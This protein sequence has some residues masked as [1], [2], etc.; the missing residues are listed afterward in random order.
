M[1][2]A[3]A[4]V[5]SLSAPA[6]AAQMKQRLYDISSGPGT[7][8]KS[9]HSVSARHDM[10]VCDA[11]YGLSNA[12]GGSAEYE[13]SYRK[14]SNHKALWKGPWETKTHRSECHPWVNTGAR[15]VY[16]RISVNGFTSL[17][18]ADVWLY[19]N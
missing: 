15:S 17:D 11:T 12:V 3:G 1:A 16:A 7:D 14:S 9:T 5:V 8:W 6:S 19:Y 2:L 4:A 18:E 13:V 10:R